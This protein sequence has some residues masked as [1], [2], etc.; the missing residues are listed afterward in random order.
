MLWVALAGPATNLALAVISAL[1]TKT[2]W[3]LAKILPYS[4]SDRSSSRSAQ[5]DADGQCLDQSGAVY[6]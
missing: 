1:L 2:L 6:F 5:W 4:A 3:V